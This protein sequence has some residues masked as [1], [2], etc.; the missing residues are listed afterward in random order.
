MQ[1]MVENPGFC[2]IIPQR[3]QS[4]IKGMSKVRNQNEAP[5][6]TLLD[7]ASDR[8][9][10]WPTLLPS[11]GVRVAFKFRLKRCAS[12]GHWAR[13]SPCR[14]LTAA[15]CWGVRRRSVTRRNGGILVEDIPGGSSTE[16][17]LGRQS[18]N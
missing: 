18:K 10:L 14:S 12:V 11:F 15:S 4:G 2:L 7:P 13:S 17:G 8:L 1:A 6:S 3:V 9:A 16:M 5:I